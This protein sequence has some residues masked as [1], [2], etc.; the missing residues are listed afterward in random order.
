[1]LGGQDRRISVC[2]DRNA[3]SNLVRL[4]V[5]S[6]Q[7][8]YFTAHTIKSGK[9]SFDETGSGPAI[10]VPTSHTPHHK[11]THTIRTSALQ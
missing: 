2:C 9:F 8:V 5:N 4:R 1:M 3:H 10:T 6:R 7:L 11:R